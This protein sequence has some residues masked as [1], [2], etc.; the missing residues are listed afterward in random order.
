MVRERLFII[1]GIGPDAV[2]LVGKITR[3]IAKHSGNIV[4]LKQDV[5]HGLFIIYLVVDMSNSTL[6]IEELKKLLKQL[7]EDTGIVFQVDNYNPIARNPH[8]KNMLLI[9]IGEDHP[10]IIASISELLGKYGVNIEFS[11][12]IGREGVFLMELLTDISLCTIPLENLKRTIIEAMKKEKIISLFQTEDVFNKKKRAVIFKISDCLMDENQRTEIIKQS[13]IN[14]TIFEKFIG[15]TTYKEI[16]STLEGFST[17]VYNSV[18]EKIVAT[19]ET[20][21]LLQ[22]LKT[23]GYKTGIIAN[24]SELLLEKISKKL[25]IDFYYGIDYKI[26]EDSQTFTGEFEKHNIDET[27]IL[28]YLSEKENINIEDITILSTSVSSDVRGI[29]PIFDLSVILNLYNNHC[30]SA[31][32]LAAMIASFGAIS[33]NKTQK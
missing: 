24:S 30:I 1:H 5:L 20:L 29:H 21:E 18:I 28:S 16:A 13:S 10:G 23:M 25:S 4:D 8:K 11:H 7:S 14:K 17:T 33:P 19:G 26:D 32:K 2:G 31:E 27:K 6:R 9:L 22:T 3:E 12:N 15:D